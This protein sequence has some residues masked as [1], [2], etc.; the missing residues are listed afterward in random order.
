V[1]E[2]EYR[3]RRYRWLRLYDRDG[4]LVPTREESERQERALREQAE[5]RIAE[6]EAELKR[7]RG[8]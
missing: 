5:R 2:G 3:G 8:E 4:N 1:W 6:L 7:L